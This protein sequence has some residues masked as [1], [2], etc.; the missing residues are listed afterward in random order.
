[1]S[2]L[3]LV[4]FTVTVW[5][6][7]VVPTPCAAKA[8]EFGVSVT[9]WAAP[10]IAASK[11]NGED[12]PSQSASFVIMRS[13]GRGFEN[14]EYLRCRRSTQLPDSAIVRNLGRSAL[15]SRTNPTVLDSRAWMARQDEGIC[16]RNLRKRIPPR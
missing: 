13:P 16:N 8:I 3:V 4:F 10:G 12:T 1:M 2:V 7:L 15:A 6:T 9:V 14:R 11:Q 5:A